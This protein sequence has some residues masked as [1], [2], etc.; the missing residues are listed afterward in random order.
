MEHR[1]RELCSQQ[2]YD[3]SS[4]DCSA[5]SHNPQS[6]NHL[7]T[8]AGL[9]H[10]GLM[11]GCTAHSFVGVMWCGRAKKCWK[12]IWA[13]RRWLLKFQTSFNHLL[14]IYFFYFYP[15]IACISGCFC[16]CC[17][18]FGFIG[19][20]PVPH[21]LVHSERMWV[22]AVTRCDVSPG[23]HTDTEDR[24]LTWPTTT[25]AREHTHTDFA[26]RLVTDDCFR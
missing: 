5:P 22:T 8:C 11:K 7:C 20:C 17:K 23:R 13:P 21:I 19:M 15:I 14:S 6:V 4:L 18:F 10:R 12:Q 2:C 26:K 25:H 9:M 24:L 3:L 16:S 1:G